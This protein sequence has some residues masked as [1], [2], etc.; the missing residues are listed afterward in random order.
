[1]AI[2]FAISGVCFSLLGA[3]VANSIDPMWLRR[4]FGILLLVM[5][6]REIFSKDKETKEKCH[7]EKDR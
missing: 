1:M 3:Y 6:I 5:G 4:G 7:I 2:P